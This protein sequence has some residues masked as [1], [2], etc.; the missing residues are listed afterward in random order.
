MRFSLLLELSL[1]RPW[2]AGDEQ[3]RVAEALEQAALADRLGYDRVWVVER[4]FLEEASHTAAAATLLGAISQRTTTIRLGFGD[5]TLAP[6]SG[7]PARTA[8]SAAMLDVLSG[9]RVDLAVGAPDTATERDGFGRR[10]PDAWAEGAGLV[11][12]MLEEL[13]FAGAES[14]WGPLPSR[15]VVPRPVQRPHPPLWLAGRRRQDV[16]L[17]ARHGLGALVLR[18]GEP[19]EVAGWVRDYEDELASERCLPVGRAVTPAI[20]VLVPM[21]VHADEAEAIQR[22]LDAAHLRAYAEGHYAS[23]GEHRPG[24]TSLAEEFRARRDDVGLARAAVQAGGEPLRVRVLGAGRSALRGAIGTPAQVVELAGRYAQVGVDELVLSVTARHEHVVETL[25]LFAREVRPQVPSPVA[26][27]E[28]GRRDAVERALARPRP[29]PDADSPPPAAM[30]PRIPR[31]VVRRAEPA[32]RAFVARAG[33]RRLEQ[34]LGSPRALR[35][36]FGEL[37]ARFAPDR[38]EGFTGDLQF[39]LHGRRPWVVSIGPGGARAWPGTAAQPALTLVLGVADLARV[40]TGELD[41]V[42]AILDG[43]LDLRGDFG[44]AMQLGEMF[45]R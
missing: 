45:P 4:H 6:G 29:T 2:E 18:P 30:R 8:A 9:G 3:R 39:E 38:A 35:L 42:R 20:A 25:E 16:R 13:P 1:P 44:V 43:R 37:A 11:A 24:V 40:A 31:A 36:L 5:L 23:F 22:G 10:G 19:E 41:P 26:A 14:A 33:D 17:A 28:S 34:V 27:G 15:T 32:L 21:H 7:H 12:R